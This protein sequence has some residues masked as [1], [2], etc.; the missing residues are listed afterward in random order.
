[1]KTNLSQTLTENRGGEES[2]PNSSYEASF[3][4][5]PKLDNSI[6]KMKTTI[7]QNYMDKPLPIKI[8]KILK[9]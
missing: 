1:M 4:Q 5:I 7:G 2:F 8:G 3:I 9:V 6:Q